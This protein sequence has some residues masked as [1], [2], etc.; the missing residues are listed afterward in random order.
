MWWCT[1][2]VEAGGLI[3]VCSGDYCVRSKTS[4]LKKKD[5]SNTHSHTN[6]HREREREVERQKKVKAT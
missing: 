4:L 5:I 6:T 2:G 1:Q 3:C